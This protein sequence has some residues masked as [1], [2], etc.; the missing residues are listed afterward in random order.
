M[1][2]CVRNDPFYDYTVAPETDGVVVIIIP[3]RLQFFVI[4]IKDNVVNQ[5]L[6]L[7]NVRVQAGGVLVG[8][9]NLVGTVREMLND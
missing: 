1:K 5:H 3:R 2:F 7:D 8:I 6:Q 4:P 9:E